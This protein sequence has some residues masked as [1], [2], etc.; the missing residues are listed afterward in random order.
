MAGSVI[1]SGAR[2]PIGRHLGALKTLESVVK[3]GDSF[4]AFVING[5]PSAGFTTLDEF[6]ELFPKSLFATS[7][8]TTTAG[9]KK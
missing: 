6:K 9:K 1:L 8:A 4:P 3:V 5:K 2:T 7:T